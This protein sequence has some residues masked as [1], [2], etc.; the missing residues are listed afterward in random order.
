M[1]II[2][3]FGDA[4]AECNELR[5]QMDLTSVDE[6]ESPSRSQLGV[7]LTLDGPSA[8]AANRLQ[9]A[10]SLP[11]G[12]EAVWGTP[13]SLPTFIGPP[14]YSPTSM[15]V[16]APPPSPCAPPP[17]PRALCLITVV[18][19]GVQARASNTTTSTYSATA[20]LCL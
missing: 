6:A 17:S 11:E 18:K 20:Y 5:W 9:L 4:T 3:G 8:A 19:L 10:S 16:F 12:V 2:G 13:P 14:P 15:A 1:R 7:A